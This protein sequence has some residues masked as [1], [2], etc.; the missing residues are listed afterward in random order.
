[1]KFHVCQDHNISGKHQ[2]HLLNGLLFSLCQ[3]SDPL[4]SIILC[5]RLYTVI[6]HN[7]DISRN[8]HGAVNVSY[9]RNP[10]LGPY[11]STYVQLIA[12]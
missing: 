7:H 1:M 3:V 4:M 2:K 12:N 9:Q 10:H 11:S 5:V 6:L 8:G